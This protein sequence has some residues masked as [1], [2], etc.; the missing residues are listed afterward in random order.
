MK[1]KPI[2]AAMAIAGALASSLAFAD[3][4]EISALRDQLELLNAQ[5]QMMEARLAD[6]ETSVIEVKT[7]ESEESVDTE[8]VAQAQGGAVVP[9]S[10]VHLA[11][12]C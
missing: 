10:V 3:G 6:A 7:Q 5:V 1:L 12:C 11:G 4:D 9:D 2:V 8:W